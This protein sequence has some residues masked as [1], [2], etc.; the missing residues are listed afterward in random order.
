V[1]YGHIDMKCFKCHEKE[2]IARE[3]SKK[4]KFKCARDK[5]AKQAM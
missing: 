2:Y 5:R 1:N 3:C 4:G